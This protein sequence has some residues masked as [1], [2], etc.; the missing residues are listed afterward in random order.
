MK[1]DKNDKFF[2][3]TEKLLRSF[4]LVIISLV[5][6]LFVLSFFFKTSESIDFQGKLVLQETQSEW[7]VEINVP[8]TKLTRVKVGMETKIFITALPYIEF[9]IFSGELIEISNL[10]IQDN[11]S[12]LTYYK[13]SVK[14]TDDKFDKYIKEGIIRP[15]L[16]AKV[17]IIIYEDYIIY[18]ILNNFFKKTKIKDG[19]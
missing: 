17:K 2:F 5:V 6:I 3:Y 13:G 7:V 12:K 11:S 14:I 9:D 10:P 19:K 16:T 4:I 1:K 15:G 18:F 8:E